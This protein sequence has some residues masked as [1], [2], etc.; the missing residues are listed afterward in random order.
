MA[1]ALR[2]QQRSDRMNRLKAFFKALADY[3]RSGK[4]RDHL[5]AAEKAALVA[6]PYISIAGD[7]LT[8]ITPTKVD[9]AARAGG[10]PGLV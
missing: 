5:Q 6:M 3:F 10:E 4:A 2:G 7:I 9:D 1:G 8:G